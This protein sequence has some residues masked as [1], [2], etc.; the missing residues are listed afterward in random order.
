MGC[1]PA[2]PPAT[3]RQGKAIPAC[4]HEQI[5]ALYHEIL[6][7]NPR[8]REW[9]E[10]RQALLRGRWRDMSQPNGERSGYETVEKG[11]IWWRMF[12]KHVAAS[13]LLTGR[14]EPREG[15]RPWIADLE[16]LVRPKN[17]PRVY[18]ISDEPQPSE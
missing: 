1:R 8:V 17:F 12:F 3:A 5:I 16:W 6:P 18:L 11:L 10:T 14:V 9:T 15:R 2:K 7:T 13:R 4:P